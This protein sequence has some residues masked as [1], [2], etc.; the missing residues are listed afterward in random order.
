MSRVRENRMHGSTGGGW[1]RDPTG[2]PRQ[3]PTQPPPSVRLS[4]TINPGQGVGYPDLWGQR[5]WD[6]QDSANCQK[7][8]IYLWLIVAIRT[9]VSL[10]EHDVQVKGEAWTRVS[11]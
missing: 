5:A 2:L 6:P 7:L 1:K 10:P 11:H 3:P 9:T 8:A 4:S